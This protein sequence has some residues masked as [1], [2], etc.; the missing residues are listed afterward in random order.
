MGRKE[1]PMLMTVRDDVTRYRIEAPDHYEVRLD[2]EGTDF[3]LV[4]DPE[5]PDVPFW[6]CDYILVEAARCGEFGL[7]LVAEEPV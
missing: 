6:L 7:K 5:E 1:E 3:L 4:P 2:L